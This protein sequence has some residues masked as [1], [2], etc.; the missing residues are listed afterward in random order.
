MNQANWNPRRRLPG[1]PGSAEEAVMIALESNP[2]LIAARERTQAA[3]YDIK[4]TDAN[5]LP[6]VSVFANTD[7]SN[8]YGSLRGVAGGSVSQSESSANAGVQVSFPLFQGGRPAAL[9]R[10]AQAVAGATMEREIATERGV[11][12]NVRAAYANWRAS[13]EIIQSTLVA[14]EAAELGLEGV[15]AENTVGNR[16]ILDILDAQREL[17]SAQVQLVTA[18]RNE[19]V[20]GF[21]LLAAMGKAEARDLNLDV[22]GPLYDPDVNLERVSDF[23]VT[24][25]SDLFWDWSDDPDPEPQSTRTIDSP[26][27]DGE[28]GPPDI[29]G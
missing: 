21:T 8:F 23:K 5:R 10:Q 17:L 6:T 11:V 24:R 18:R 20:A 26:V 13:R 19:Y 15:Q 27:Q 12:A 1:L 9:K 16:T 4:A 2:D 7:Y 28:I 22:G 29:G 3:R 25:P 14:V